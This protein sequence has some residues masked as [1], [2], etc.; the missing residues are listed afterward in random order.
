MFLA[1]SPFAGSMFVVIY[2]EDN[3]RYFT[4]NSNLKSGTLC[5][6]RSPFLANREHQIVEGMLYQ[7]ENGANLIELFTI[8]CI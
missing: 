2:T 6:G 4:G 1:I 7:P 5:G 3:I 8:A